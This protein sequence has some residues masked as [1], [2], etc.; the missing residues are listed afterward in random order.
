MIYRIPGGRRRGFRSPI[1]A[2]GNN[3][4][5]R[6]DDHP[7]LAELIAQTATLR[8]LLQ[9]PGIRQGLGDDPFRLLAALNRLAPENLVVA[10]TPLDRAG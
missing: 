5:M 2:E 7:S 1:A 3:A 9:E 10:P 4:A 6:A 8:Q